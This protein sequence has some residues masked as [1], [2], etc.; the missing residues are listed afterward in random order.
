MLLYL[1]DVTLRGAPAPRKKNEVTFI[2]DDTRQ[3]LSNADYQLFIMDKMVW[4]SLLN[5]CTI[6]NLYS[7]YSLVSEIG[8]IGNV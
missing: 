4:Y 7:E 6:F 2:V 1:I 5:Y 3:I 8:F